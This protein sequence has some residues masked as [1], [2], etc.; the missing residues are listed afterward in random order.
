MQKPLNIGG[1]AV[2]EGVMIRVPSKYSVAV[3]KGKQIV[4][5]SWNLKRT[6]FHSTNGILLGVL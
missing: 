6:S 2:I 4:S 1:Q 3:R 5:K